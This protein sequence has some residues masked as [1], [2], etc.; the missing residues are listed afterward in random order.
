MQSIQKLQLAFRVDMPPS[1]V[2]G[3]W[4]NGERVVDEN[5]RVA[6]CGKP[7]N[8]IREFTV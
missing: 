2:S 3:V 4:V 6:N 7:G 1:G 5:G 8:L